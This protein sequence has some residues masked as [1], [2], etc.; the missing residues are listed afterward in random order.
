MITTPSDF[1]LLAQVAKATESALFDAAY[2]A[3]AEEPQLAPE[4]NEAMDIIANVLLDWLSKAR[5][6]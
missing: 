4:L 2:A 5:A 3:M 6:T 1:I